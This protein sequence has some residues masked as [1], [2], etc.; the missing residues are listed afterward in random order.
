MDSVSYRVTARLETKLSGIYE[1]LNKKEKEISQRINL[2]VKDHKHN[3]AHQALLVHLSLNAFA[4]AGL[5][6]LFF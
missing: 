3:N 5:Y 2:Y 6:Y 4:M 1:I